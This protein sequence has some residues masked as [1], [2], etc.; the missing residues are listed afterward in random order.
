[1]QTLNPDQDKLVATWKREEQ[2]PFTGWDFSY[3]DGRMF[4]EVSVTRFSPLCQPDSYLG[5]GSII[6]AIREGKE[7][8]HDDRC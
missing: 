3:L 4:E 2:Q 5:K 6:G 1:M 8:P 7:L